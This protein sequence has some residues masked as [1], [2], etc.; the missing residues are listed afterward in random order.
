GPAGAQGPP[1]ATGAAYKATAAGPAIAPNA[2]TTI[3]SIALPGGG[4]WVVTAKFVANNTG[5]DALNL[6]CRLLIDGVEK[7]TVATDFGAGTGAHMLTG[8]GGGSTASIACT[9]DATAGSYSAISFTAI[10]VA[11]IG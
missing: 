2:A 6:T 4:S 7:D 8:A 3:D 9:T 11:S 10:R 1:G 5:A